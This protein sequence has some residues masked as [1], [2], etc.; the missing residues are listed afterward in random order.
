MT[1][2]ACGWMENEWMQTL[3]AADKQF[4]KAKR[5]MDDI[6][7]TYVET[8]RWDAKGFVE[9]MQSSVCYQEPLELERGHDGTFLETRFTIENNVFRYK[10]KNDNE[11]GEMH[12]WRYMHFHANAPFVQKRATLTACLK[13]VQKMSSDAANLYGSAMDKVAEFRRLRY[14]TALLRKACSYLGATTGVREWLDVRD[15]L[16]W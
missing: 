1:L 3:A 12:V 5:F 16:R 9:D 11:D 15:S 7:L 8:P 14:P 13:K 4:F 10:L 2:A 6:L